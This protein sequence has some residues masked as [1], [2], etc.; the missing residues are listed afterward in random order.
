MTHKIGAKT[1]VA[2]GSAKHQAQGS[3]GHNHRQQAAAGQAAGST[4]A[5]A[6][7]NPVTLVSCPNITVAACASECGRVCLDSGA[8]RELVET[9]CE[10]AKD[11]C[12]LGKARTNLALVVMVLTLILLARRRW[13]LF[14]VGR[15]M[16]AGIGATALVSMGVLDL[17]SV[18]NSRSSLDMNNLASLFA[19]TILSGY[20][21][22][23]QADGMLVS[24]LSFKCRSPTGL[25]ARVMLFA[26]VLAGVVT[27]DAC[28]LMLSVPVLDAAAQLGA[29]HEP[30]LLALATSAHIGGAA[31]PI[32]SSAT[33]LVVAASGINGLDWATWMAV[34]AVGAL[35]TNF[36]LLRLVYCRSLGAFGEQRASGGDALLGSSSRAQRRHS[37]YLTAQLIENKEQ[38]SAMAAAANGGNRSSRRPVGNGIAVQISKLLVAASIPAILAGFLIS[39][40][41]AWSALSGVCVLTI[42]EVF[43]RGGEGTN[44]LRHVDAPL[45]LL[46]CAIG[47]ITAGAK[48]TGAPE[49]LYGLYGQMDAPPQDAQ[50]WMFDS[51]FD[52]AQDVISCCMMVLLLTAGCTDVVAVGLLSSIY[53][54]TLWL[55]PS[56][57]IG[58]PRL[59]A[60]LMLGFSANVA[61]NF[62]LGLSL[63]NLIIVEK[64]AASGVSM[65]W[66][67]WFR[68]SSWSTVL[69][70]AE[71][72]ALLFYVVQPM[73]I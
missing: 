18:L 64:A 23:F 12:T 26:F 9:C 55:E 63:C 54:Q 49:R 53:S 67:S 34:P 5:M 1:S 72:G 39:G 51:D 62:W 13:K 14:P 10:C 70:L 44:V 35:V 56:A 52:S 57:A 47:L 6:T 50:W 45:M 65:G 21:T 11:T 30:M 3:S 66:W 7:P 37:E 48:V 19:F 33:L 17:K 27:A 46:L 38:Q 40:S 2:L 8:I 32:G 4:T 43:L 73:L 22:E 29:P 24:A 60:W 42:I 36:L 68:Y 69:T 20:L 31:S 25:L 71:G 59:L 28:V 58:N 61:A 15:A 16:G 41:I